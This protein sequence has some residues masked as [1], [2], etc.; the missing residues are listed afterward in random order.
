M[1]P[2]KKTP[3][4]TSNTSANTSASF[5]M[6]Y[7]PLTSHFC[8]LQ[9]TIRTSKVCRQTQRRLPPDITSSQP[10]ASSRHLEDGAE[11][12][13][14]HLALTILANAVLRRNRIS[15]TP[16]TLIQ[17]TP[18]R[19]LARRLLSA[20]TTDRGLRM[21]ITRTSRN[22]KRRRKCSPKIRPEGSRQISSSCRNC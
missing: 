21:F 4:A 7:N 9:E 10:T 19:T 22:D 3:L 6:T 18:S 1:E 13:P 16:A 8:C 11:L 2:S 17:I 15:L 20:I 12:R 14:H 5:H